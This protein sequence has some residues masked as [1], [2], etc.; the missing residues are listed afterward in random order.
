MRKTILLAS[1]S[2]PLAA[3]TMGPDYAGPPV[4]AGFGQKNIGF[5]RGGDAVRSESPSLDSWWKTLGDPTLDTL[6]ERALKGS[7]SIAIAEARLRQARATVRQDRADQLPSGS[8]SASYLH[9]DLPGINVGEAQ[10]S[11]DSSD[12][13]ASGDSSTSLDFYNVGFD[14]SWE[15]DLFGGKRRTVEASRALVT[16]AEADVADAQVSLSAEVAQ[17]YVNLRDSQHQLSLAREAAQ[18]QQ[19]TLDLA[20]QR[21][22]RGVDSALDI[23]RLRN[24]VESS[25]ARLV[26]LSAQI[27]SYLNALAVLTGD[28]PGALDAMLRPSAPV[29]LPPRSVAVGDPAELLRRRPDIR[30]AERRLAAQT[31]RIGAADAARFPHLQLLGLLG[32]GG[33]D[34][35]DIL[36][37]DN[38]TSVAAPMLQWNVLD[39]GKSAG[40]VEQA[41]GQADEAEAQYRQTVLQALRDA[42]DALSR[43]GGR[44]K[45]L[46][47]LARAETAATRAATFTR[48]RYQAGTVALGDVLDSERQRVSAERDLSSAKAELANDFIALQKALGLGWKARD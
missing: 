7:P 25:N 10:G 32:L 45:Q 15:I 48:Q 22:A 39:F 4:V 1:L 40:R 42:E 44:R 43:Y 38:L 16:A 33:T 41:K 46:G 11:T 17:N 14:A 29:P 13:T 24:Q 20:M 36:D 30:A 12:E 23:D 6:E 27:D 47:G 26:P 31:A 2:L 35:S 8:A 3:C 19:T 5:V 9:A 37:L 28:A 21:Q 34:P 18:M